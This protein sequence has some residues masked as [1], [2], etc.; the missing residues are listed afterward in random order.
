MVVL[1]FVT[2]FLT[3]SAD[4]PFAEKPTCG[5]IVDPDRESCREGECDGNAR[6][7]YHSQDGVCFCRQENTSRMRLGDVKKKRKK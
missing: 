3:V 6:C 1:V 7:S 4:E 5:D 2:S